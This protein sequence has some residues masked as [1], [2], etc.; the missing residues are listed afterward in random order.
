MEIDEQMTNIT[1]IHLAADHAG[2]EMKEMVHD[3]LVSEGYEVVDH[4]AHEYEERDDY[5]D[6]VAPAA[7]AVSVDPERKT[8][9]IILGGSGQGEAIMANR[10]VN[11]RAVV[12][13]GQYYSPELEGR[14]IPEEITTARQHNDANILSLGAR[15]LSDG[16]ARDAI[17]QFL[18]TD[19][20]HEDRHIRRIQKIDEAKTFYESE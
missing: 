6:Y 5:P 2:F 17:T 14:E 10:F 1:T 11:V 18:E 3:W 15:F 8:R 20:S 7:H 12:F 19:F 16:E 4:G 13:N 9:A